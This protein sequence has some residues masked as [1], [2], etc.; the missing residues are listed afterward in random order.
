MNTLF[1]QFFAAAFAKF[2]QKSPIIAGII[3]FA[4]LVIVYAADQGTALGIF[5]LPQ[6]AADTVKYVGMILLAV[7]GAHTSQY[8]PN[9]KE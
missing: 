2:K 4:L 3:A 7:N 5:T 1:L 9:D 8:L 6:W